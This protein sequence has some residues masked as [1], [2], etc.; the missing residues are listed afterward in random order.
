[1][2]A[3]PFPPYGSIVTEYKVTFQAGRFL[4]VEG[5]AMRSSGSE[6]ELW[7]NDPA[8][9]DRIQKLFDAGVPRSCNLCGRVEDPRPDEEVKTLS[10][11]ECHRPLPCNGKP[12][13]SANGVDLTDLVRS[14]VS[15][16]E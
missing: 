13:A 8:D 5:R 15:G 7:T 10:C 14:H 3:L 1:M 9:L 16:N 6:V 4:A 2:P 11:F 12:S